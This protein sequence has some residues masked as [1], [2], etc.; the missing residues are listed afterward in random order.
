MFIIG[1]RNTEIESAM[2]EEEVEL[3]TTQWT[4]HVELMLY[5]QAEIEERLETLGYDLGSLPHR[6]LL[7][8]IDENLDDITTT[9]E[10]TKIINQQEKHRNRQGYKSQFQYTDAEEEAYLQ[11]P[12]ICSDID[13]DIIN[14]DEFVSYF[15]QDPEI[16]DPLAYPRYFNGAVHPLVLKALYHRGCGSGVGIM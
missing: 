3:Y 10:V 1:Y 6:K 12:T 2:I 5:Q 9:I 8:Q 13:I 16:T 15:N 11:A 14:Q 7:D 4:N